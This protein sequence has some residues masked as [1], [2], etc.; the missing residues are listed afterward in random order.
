MPQ[1]ETVPALINR[2][3]H[4]LESRDLEGA[5]ACFAADA[6]LIDHH[7]PYPEMRGLDEIRSGLEWGL[8]GMESMSFEP[9]TF[10]TSEDGHSVVVELA[11]HHV[12]KGGGKL[13]F[14]QIFVVDTR[15]GL[16]TRM[17]S[18]LPYGPNGFGGFMLRM[19]H[20]GYRLRHRKP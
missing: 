20:R 2:A 1:T 7:Y 19:I 6:V 9:T 4:A 14:P 18:Y 13:D 5:L 11:T 10:F 3:F 16:I 15:D 12:Q 17:Q 8:A